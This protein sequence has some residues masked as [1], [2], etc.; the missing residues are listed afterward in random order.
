MSTISGVNGVSDAASTYKSYAGTSKTDA[1]DTNTKND[2]GV[3]YEKSSDTDTKKASTKASNADIVAQMKADAE[4]RTAQLQSIVQKMISGQG[5]SYGQANDIWKFLAS[6]KYTVDPAT[7]AQAQADIAEDGYW[8]VNQ[9]SDRIIDFAKAL[10]GDDA[11]QIEKM[12]A[13]FEKGFKAATKA[14]GKDLP[15]ISSKTYDAVMTKFDNW[16]KEANGTVTE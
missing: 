4:Q 8:G 1:K 9:T 6:G 16:S 10:C 5:N 3:V 11:T 14:W 7:K 2:T 15:D 13:A 12:R